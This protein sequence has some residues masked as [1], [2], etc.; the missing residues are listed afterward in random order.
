MIKIARRV[1]RSGSRNG[2]ILVAALWLLAAL[3]TLASVVSVYMAQSARALTAFDTALQSET[4]ATAGLELAAYQ[5]SAPAAARRPTHGG[6]SFRLAK[7]EV[8]VGYMSEAARINLNMAPASMIAGL[9]TAL[10]AQAEKAEEYADRVVGWR[11]KPRPNVEDEEGALYRAAGLNY[12]PR[13]GYFDS[14]DELW[15]VLGL[16][17]DLVERALPFVTIYSGT[18]DIDVLNA[19]PQVMAALPD[20]TPA[21]LQSFLDERESLSPDLQQVVGVLGGKQAGVTVTGSE[22]YRVR[23]RITLPDGQQRT[24]EGVITI[25]GPNAK[26]AFRV[27]AWK[28]EVDPNTGRTRGSA[29]I[30]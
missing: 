19:A 1:D 20:M 9:F 27:L 22:T 8:T 11:S 10:G 29:E 4:L 7:S 2:F 16:P 5:L 17:P 15:L 24:P 28:D 13:H 14:V 18:A 12:L 3:A 30:R 21:L 26:G 25:L 23:M 6:F